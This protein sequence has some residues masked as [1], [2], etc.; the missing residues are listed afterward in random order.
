MKP[1]IIYII[2]VCSILSSIFASCGN[3]GVKG[4]GNVISQEIP[5]EIYNEI[6][7][8]GA[9]DL[10]YESKPDEA[11]Y[12]R[13]E[14]D[15]NILPLLEIKVKGKTL[16]I[17]AKESI[18]P[19]RFAIYTNS[20]TIKYVESKGAASIHL[21]GHI[22]GKELKVKLKGAGDLK[23]DNIAFEKAE[24]FLEGAGNMDLSG[25]AGKAKLEISGN[26]DINSGGLQVGELECH[27]KGNGD[28]DVNATDKL[29]IEIKGK[30]N[31][32]YKGKPQITK[33]NIK[34]AGTV[35]A[36]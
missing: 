35:K 9:L 1:N 8:D 2:S 26:G 36:K 23:A 21:T 19:S 17:R 7:A 33:Q 13:V 31:L 10:V 27:I 22:E 28:M 25:E 16:N 14:A 20:P 32:T 3:N 6:K 11:A 12:L 29:S 18:N 34:G 24:F 30:G 5:V 15:D 4:D